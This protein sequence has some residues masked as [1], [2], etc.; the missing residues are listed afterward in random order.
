MESTELRN[1]K[2]TGQ[3]ECRHSIPIKKHRQLLDVPERS[4]VSI[5]K[6]RCD[7]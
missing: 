5:G 6:L 1:W 3:V 4:C 7:V 2:L